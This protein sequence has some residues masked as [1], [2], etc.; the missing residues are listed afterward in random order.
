MFTVIPKLALNY[1]QFYA[2]VVKHLTYLPFHI[3][4]S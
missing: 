4:R 3:A 1:F 2:V